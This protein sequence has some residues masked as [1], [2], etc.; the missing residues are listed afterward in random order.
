[1]VEAVYYKLAWHK[2]DNIPIK[3]ILVY[4]ESIPLSEEDLEKLQ[5][6]EKLQKHVEL[7]ENI[8]LDMNLRDFFNYGAEVIRKLSKYYI[9]EV[10]PLSRQSAEAEAESESITFM[11]IFEIMLKIRDDLFKDTLSDRKVLEVVISHA[12]SF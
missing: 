8:G 9:E 3:D 11:D 4:F 12:M 1:L 2:N 6:I 5:Q 10:L 7:F